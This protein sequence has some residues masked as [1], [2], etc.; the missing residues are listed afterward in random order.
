MSWESIGSTS[1]GQMPHDR[2]WIVFSLE[3]A[4]RYVALVCGEPPSG[5]KLDIMWNE[6][7]LGSYP[8]LGVWSEY[9]TPYD[10][11]NACERALEVFDEAVSWSEL[12]EHFEEVAFSEDDDDQAE[13]DDDQAEDDDDET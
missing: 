9:D 6:H 13:D 7:E 8:S 2:D 3:L 4:K 12:Q 10:Y 1:T 5:S 11:I